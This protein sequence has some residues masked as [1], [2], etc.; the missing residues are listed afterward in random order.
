MLTL[1]T[2]LSSLFASRMA[3]GEA[4]SGTPKRRQELSLAVDISCRSHVAKVKCFAICA[5]SA[6]KFPAWSC[7]GI[8]HEIPYQAHLYA[9]SRVGSKSSYI[10]RCKLSVWESVSSQNTH[11]KH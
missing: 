8:N 5:R 2:R 9:G 3:S 7:K 11:F 4:V 6:A 1:T 10:L